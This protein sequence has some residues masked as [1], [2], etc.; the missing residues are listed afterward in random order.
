MSEFVKASGSHKGRGQEPTS[1]WRVKVWTAKGETMRGFSDFHAAAEWMR[2]EGFQPR[3][4]P[5]GTEEKATVPPK[6]KRARR[7]GQ[8]VP[9]QPECAPQPATAGDPSQPGYWLSRLGSVADRLL[10]DEDL[11]VLKVSRCLSQLATAARGHADQAQLAEKVAAMEQAFQDM[12]SAEDYGTA[13]AWRPG[14]PDDELD[15]ETH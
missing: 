5:P 15:G 9:V 2:R 13:S 6:P 11:D 1:Q 4:A 8:S 7:A 12:Q 14:L 10:G 3:A